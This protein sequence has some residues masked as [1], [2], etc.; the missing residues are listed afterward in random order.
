MSLPLRRPRRRPA[1]LAAACV[2]SLAATMAPLTQVASSAQEPPAPLDAGVSDFF[3]P[4][5]VTVDVGGPEDKARLQ[6]L[7][8]DLTEHAGHDYIEVVLHTAADLRSLVDNKFDYDVRIPDLIKRDLQIRELDKA[9]AARVGSSP[10]PSGRTGYRTL[11]DYNSDMVKLEKNNK[12]IVKRIKL[13][14]PTMDGR[15]VFG[16]EI[17]KNVRKANTGKPT[18]LL[19]G[20]HHA[21]EWP[22]GELAM[23][24]AI[25]LAKSYGKNKQITKL[26]GKARVIVV[27]VVNADG[28]DLSRTDGEFVDLRDL[29]DYDPLE[30]TTSILATPGRAYMRKN[31]RIV[32]GEDTPDGSC[33][34]LLATPGGFGAGTDL[35]RNYG[36]LWGGPGADTL[37]ADP[38]Y[39]GAEAFSEPETQNIQDLVR[40]RNIT[41][42]I[43]NHT[44]SNL[45][46]RPNGV[47]PTTIGSDGLPVGDAPDEK[48][49]KKLG[50]KI[51]AQ[52]GYANIHG[53]QLYDTTGTTEDYSYNATGGF[54]YTFEIG[55]NEF[56]PPY[57]EVVDEYVGAGK[58]AGK[59]N[60]KAYIIALKHAV[61]TRYSGTLKGKAPRGATLRLAKTFDTPTWESSFEDFVDTSITVPKSGRFSWIVNPSTRPAVASKTYEVPKDKPFASQVDTEPVA[62]PLG[63]TDIEFVLPR[64]GSH[65]NI[66]QSQRRQQ[67]QPRNPGQ[68]A[69]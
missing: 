28:F 16:V 27:P 62:P 22:S 47:N 50:A 43:S 3:A 61:D 33:A 2:F 26:L 42:L 55:P 65:V 49:L 29:N 30:G 40:T 5:L 18:F 34:A 46:L 7:G 6:S 17:G 24:F 35:N 36:G 13:A 25:D 45:L 51:T 54:G 31:C 20:V 32:D 56:H 4:R 23:E 14:R 21:R 11:A 48:D 44:F 1:A 57:E 66:D 15:D 52:N 63:S 67:N 60:R 53:W 38:T 9:Y 68:A 41:M 10:L 37:N 69:D 59:G 19:M 8:L 12:K 64:T 39:R 58:Y